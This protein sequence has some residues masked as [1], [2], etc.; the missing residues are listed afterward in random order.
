MP[1]GCERAHQGDAVYLLHGG[2]EVTCAP[3]FLF[4]LQVDA[5]CAVGPGGFEALRRGG[6]PP[7]PW[8]AALPTRGGRA[9]LVVH[10]LGVGRTAVVGAAVL[11]GWG[12]LGGVVLHAPLPG[13]GARLWC[14]PARVA[15]APFGH[16]LRHL[17]HAEATLSVVAQVPQLHCRQHSYLL[18]GPCQQG[19]PVGCHCCAVRHRALLARQP[20][21]HHIDEVG[22]GVLSP[23]VH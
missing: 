16:L 5:S 22:E 11:S 8:V 1:E 3:V 2:L 20:E 23:L 21:L 6:I 17:A 18:A 10:A 7:V 19:A 12:P 14:L 9:L 13:F 15:V 4:R